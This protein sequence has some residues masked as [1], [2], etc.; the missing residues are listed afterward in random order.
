MGL[1]GYGLLCCCCL[2]EVCAE[3]KE[4]GWRVGEL[5]AIDIQG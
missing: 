1:R 4:E 3:G 2:V 5:L